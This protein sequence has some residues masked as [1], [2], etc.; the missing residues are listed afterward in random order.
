[1]DGRDHRAPVRGRP[2][3]LGGNVTGLVD[4]GDTN[5]DISKLYFDSEAFGERLRELVEADG[6]SQELFAFRIGCSKAAVSLWLS[7]KRSPG[8]EYMCR[9]SLY[10]GVSLDW[11]MMGY[12]S[13]YGS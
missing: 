9:L 1:M 3:K 2:C 5:I 11:L 6:V 4:R 10:F 13:A 8:A 7:G 12:G